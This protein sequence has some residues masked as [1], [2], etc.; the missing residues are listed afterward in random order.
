M[1]SSILVQSL[2]QILDQNR[3]VSEGEKLAEEYVAAVD[4]VNQR[5]K[6]IL[7]SIEAGQTSDAIQQ[8]DED[9]PVYEEASTLN[10]YRLSD[11]QKICG[12]ECW[13][14][15]QVIDLNLLE[16][17]DM[18]CKEVRSL[19]ETHRRASRTHDA[20]ADI[21]ALH[22]LMEVD[23]SQNWQP[24]LQ[25]AED[26]LQEELIKNFKLA[27]E[28]KNTAKAAEI[29][30][31][32]AGFSWSKLPTIPGADDIRF[33]IN[34]LK[35]KD[36][37]AEGEMMLKQLRAYLEKDWSTP[38]V[39]VLIDRM[40]TLEERGFA[41]DPNA[42]TLIQ[43]CRDRI[44]KEK[45]TAAEEAA[46]KR[47]EAEEQAKQKAAEEEFL[48]K[49]QAACEVLHTAVQTGK[50]A[51]V[52][53]ALGAPE[54]LQRAARE[55]LL[56]QANDV[57]RQEKKRRATTFISIITLLVVLALSAISVLHFYM[58]SKLH[59]ERCTREVK[60]LQQIANSPTADSDKRLAI[61]LSELKTSS[62]KIYE[63]TRIREFVQTLKSMQR[64]KFDD[65]C[66]A[67]TNR[68]ALILK[69]PDGETK[70]DAAIQALQTNSPAIYADAR[71]TTFLKHA[72]NLKEQHRK[73][74]Q[75]IQDL[76]AQLKSLQTQKAW[77]RDEAA[78]TNLIGRI[79]ALLLP[80]DTEA[81][82]TL[83]TI[84]TDWTAFENKI[85]AAKSQ[86]ATLLSNLA[87]V[88]RRLKTEVLPEAQNLQ[89]EI[90]ACKEGIEKWKAINDMYG[91]NLWDDVIAA[92]RVLLDAEKMQAHVQA[93]LKKL[94]DARTVQDY[95]TQRDAL[96]EQA[97][98]YNFTR[99]IEDYGISPAD[100]Q[101]LTRGK[102][103]A[104]KTIQTTASRSAALSLE[105]FKNFL[106]TKVFALT[107]SL[108]ETALYG[109]YYS[110]V[111]IDSS[112][113]TSNAHRKFIGLSRG[114][115]KIQ[116][117]G[118][119]TTV[120][121]DLFETSAE[122]C[123]RLQFHK[124]RPSPLKTIEMGSSAELNALIKFAAQ[125]NMTPEKFA[126]ELERLIAE[127]LSV[128][129][130]TDNRDEFFYPATRRVQMIWRYF[131]W[132]HNDLHMLPIEGVIG[133]CYALAEELAQPVEL[134]PIPI[135]LTWACLK[136]EPIQERN[137][138]CHEYLLSLAQN[139][140]MLRL[141]RAR[142]AHKKLEQATTWHAE[143]VGAINCPS[144]SQWR[145]NPTK[146]YLSLIDEQS[147]TKLP[148][149]VLRT[150]NDT[151]YFVRVLE[152]RDSG[153]GL[154]IVS[155]MGQ[156]LFSGDPLFQIKSGDDVID[157]ERFV[158]NLKAD[159]PDINLA[160]LAPYY[161]QPQGD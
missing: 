34:E 134:S 76:L 32:F 113:S 153:E 124:P 87:R 8:M 12:K 118:E 137:K 29:A 106:A 80:T 79:N 15:P 140:F 144:L 145:A 33:F 121:G 2:T 48:A 20:R 68:L 61:A 128:G 130:L 30:H 31:E 152:A 126:H 75:T 92:Q 47:K 85:A 45:E 56:K 77:G 78:V 112:P 41:L 40:R 60:R 107:N 131:Q 135:A 151:P 70:F 24:D 81:K 89:L 28:A 114:E 97:S 55:D 71:V 36:L 132:L 17:C 83:E 88:T 42:R 161:T 146:F 1:N 95:L 99:H 74:N 62:P 158:K 43:N 50:S 59:N 6:T 63:D 86:H 66:I 110:S 160:P 27:Q 100:A 10:F 91:L 125:P 38:R 65:T 18:S 64:K 67:T 120:I 122:P 111:N 136:T 147:K 105:D 54:F 159:W 44:K 143:F 16:R 69:G 35:Q 138:L 116:H 39:S 150:E 82:T 5:L 102:S 57:F 49:W 149:Y 156:H 25:Q 155:G 51:E 11:W 115:A 148:L 37:E 142:E 117:A 52:R 84:T 53:K 19:L 127:Q 93:E 98:T 123:A 3:P 7:E 13:P 157:V 129:S 21:P 103:A 14:L 154:R 94:N 4:R 101:A 119:S 22:K 58:Q 104:P 108:L 139:D 9:P 46:R 73:R 141:R 72:H 96:L 23:K 109:V 133:R 90:E 26:I